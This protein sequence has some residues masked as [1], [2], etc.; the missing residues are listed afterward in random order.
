MRYPTLT[1]L[2][3]YLHYRWVAA[4]AKGHGIHSPFVFSLVTAQMNATKTRELIKYRDPSIN[5]IMQEIEA[6]I[7]YSMPEKIKR[8]ITR[9]IDLFQPNSFCVIGEN[10]VDKNYTNKASIDFAFFSDRNKKATLLH[11]ANLVVQKMHSSS[12]IVLHGIHT[13]SEMEA[14]WEMLKKHPQI[15]LTIDLF[16]IGLLFCRK[17]QKEQEHFIIRY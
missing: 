7:T 12:W 6:V 4:N 3:K 5:K 16:N 9:L 14:A 1:I 15:R 11:D 8:L 13:S 17:E 10:G 2:L